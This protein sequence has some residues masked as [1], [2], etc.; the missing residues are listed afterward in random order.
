[1]NPSGKS[2]GVPALGGALSVIAV[3]GYGLSGLPP[4]TPEVIGAVSTVFVIATQTL[5]R[6]L[7]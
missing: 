7:D 6:W 1:M 4:L 2:L 3:W 5:A